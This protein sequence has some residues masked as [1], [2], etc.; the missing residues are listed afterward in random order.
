METQLIYCNCCE[1]AKV[2]TTEIVTD[3]TFYLC[4]MCREYAE[5]LGVDVKEN[6]FKEELV[7]DY[8]N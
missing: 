6:N 5:H 1:S 2:E 3:T 7:T 4:T 8:S